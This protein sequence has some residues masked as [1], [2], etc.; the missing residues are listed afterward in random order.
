MA[1]IAYEFNYDGTRATFWGYIQTALVNFGWELHDNISATVKVYKSNGE[2]GVEPYGYVWIDAGTSTY[3]QF[4]FYQYWNNAAHTGVRLRYPNNYAAYG[5][6][7]VTYLQA[8]YPAFIAGDKDM[9][10]IIANVLGTGNVNCGVGFGHLPIRFDN[11]LT[12]AVGTAGTAGT[13]TIASSA[14]QG[15]GKRIQIVG[16]EGCDSLVISAA[17]DGTT[18]LLS[19]LPRSYS[20]GAKIGAPASTFGCLCIPQST[21]VWYPTSLWGDSGVTVGTGTVSISGMTSPAI[22]SVILYNEGKYALSPL[23]LISVSTTTPGQMLGS[24]GNNFLYASGFSS[25]VWMDAALINNDGSFA[26]TYYATLVEANKIAD[27]AQ[28]WAVNEHAGRFC[29]IAGG[30]GAGAVRLISSN[31]SDT[32]TLDSNWISEYYPVVASEF[33]I[34]DAVYRAMPS[35]F[36]SCGLLKITR[37]DIPT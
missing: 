7:T 23:Y 12:G 18:R 16:A 27:S 9:V 24:F 19:A 21:A 14:G 36:A 8:T 33:K 20:S 3:I 34:V 26:R 5:Q 4:A 22:S 25:A 28:S 35:V 31:T 1:Y 6:I 17:P 10:I 30:R 15:V 32:L 13:I 2:S 11:N 37:T 29:C